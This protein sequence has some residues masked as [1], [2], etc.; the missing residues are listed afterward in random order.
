MYYI[1]IFIIVIVTTGYKQNIEES[2][3]LFGSSERVKSM[4]IWNNSRMHTGFSQNL[5]PTFSQKLLI[6]ASFD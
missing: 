2:D 5:L 6:H 4:F 3:L 1:L